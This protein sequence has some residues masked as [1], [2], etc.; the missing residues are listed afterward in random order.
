MSAEPQAL[1]RIARNYWI[2]SI[3][4]LEVQE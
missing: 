2:G 4:P 1:R 3:E